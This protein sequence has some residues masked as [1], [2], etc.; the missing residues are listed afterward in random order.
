MEEQK[1]KAHDAHRTTNYMG[2]EETV[3]QQLDPSLV[4]EFTGYDSLVSDSVITALTTETEVV[5][6]LSDG[7][8]G[9]IIT[10]QTPFYA[11]MG[12]QQADVGV[13]LVGENEFRVKDT[14]K[15]QGGRIG[16]VGTVV[17]GMFKNGDMVTL[18]VEQKKRLATG[19]NHSATHL[20][21][22]ALRMVLGSHVEQ[23]AS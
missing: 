9:T 19:K 7:E 11:T 5:Q 18:K 8:K 10:S 20:V 12:G 15:L 6:A 22:K 17:K 14:I 1:K 23:A 16:H 4:T 3:Y 2:T 21:Q 13:I